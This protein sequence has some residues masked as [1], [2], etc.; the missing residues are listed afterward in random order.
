M[1][2]ALFA[3]CDGVIEL[4]TLPKAASAF[5]PADD[6]AAVTAYLRQQADQNCYWGV[7]TRRDA[8]SGSL[9]NCLHLPALFVDLDDK[10]RPSA[11]V[12]ALRAAF[13]FKPS[14]IV[15]SGG[16]EH[17]YWLLREPLNLQDPGDR[18]LA[19]DILR[20]LATYL[21]GD[22]P[23]A[24][25]ARILRVPSTSN[26]KYQPARIA[27]ARVLAADR[28]YNASELQDWL[29]AGEMTTAPASRV[30]LAKPVNR[31]RN[32]SLYRL[33]RSL[34]A[35]GLPPVVLTE[36]IAFINQRCC[37]PPLEA[38]E[39]AQITAHVLQQADRPPVANPS[40]RTTFSVKVV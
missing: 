17:W 14:I 30:D 12:V 11:E 2:A 25:P 4:R 34:K 6:I 32:V 3:E 18:T 35:K 23:V 10:H 8:S 16:G 29:P 38:W 24:E 20:R 22:L 1:L 36:A 39:V 13:P 9:A 28:R 31:Q 33:G 21:S 26:W 40:A 7:A 15:N 27:T 19:Y 5:Y 37:R